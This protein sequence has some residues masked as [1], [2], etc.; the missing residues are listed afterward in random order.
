MMT[1]VEIIEENLTPLAN[2]PHG[3]FYL[4]SLL[5][6]TVLV[7]TFMTLIYILLCKQY[8]KRIRRLDNRQDAYCGYRLQRLKEALIDLEYE[9][10]K[11]VDLF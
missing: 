5:G 9:K 7:I 11:F 1:R 3:D 2:V 8:H 10:L 4:V 6:L